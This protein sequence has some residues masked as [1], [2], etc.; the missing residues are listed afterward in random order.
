MYI[1]GKYIPVEIGAVRFPVLSL[2]YEDIVYLTYEKDGLHPTV[3]YHDAVGEK[4]EGCL[5]PGQR[6]RVGDKTQF[7]VC[8]TNNA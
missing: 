8:F 5:I 4:T 3:V 6:V 1:N 7:S 2:S